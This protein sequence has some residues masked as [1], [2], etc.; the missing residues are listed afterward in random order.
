MVPF[1]R[2]WTQPVCS[3]ESCSNRSQSMVS[4]LI[5]LCGGDREQSLGC[6]GSLACRI[7]TGNGALVLNYKGM[8]RHRLR[9]KTFFSSCA[10]P[11]SGPAS[12]R[13]HFPQSNLL[14]DLRWH[15]S[16]FSTL[17]S[18][19]DFT[20]CLKY[21]TRTEQNQGKRS[22]NNSGQLV[23]TKKALHFL[24][25]SNVKIY[26]LITKWSLQLA[27][28]L[29]RHGNKVEHTHEQVRMSVCVHFMSILIRST[30]C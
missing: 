30:F 19:L 14:H 3:V 10:Q 23:I 9:F 7:V 12:V 1:T 22:A 27:P 6:E 13:P 5:S 26:L 28:S 15:L 29:T 11:A 16:F 17:F 4:T 18:I 8:H 21:K 20:F 2:G 25:S 24:F